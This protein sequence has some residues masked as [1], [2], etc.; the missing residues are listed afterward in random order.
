MMVGNLCIIEDNGKVLLKLATRGVSKG[1]WN[2]PGGKIEDG[3]TSEQSTKRE[4]L[5]ETGLVVDAMRLVGKL[6]FYDGEK[7]FFFVDVY[8]AGGF[9][10]TIRETKEGP[11][12]WFD[13]SSIPFDKTWEDDKYWFPEIMRGRRI[14]GEFHFAEGVGSLTRHSITDL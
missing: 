13:V 7:P 2:F 6:E 5:E 11:L 10:G 14:K 1:K 8:K 3:E 9:S 4:V 12:Q